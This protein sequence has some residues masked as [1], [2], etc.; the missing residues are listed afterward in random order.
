MKRI[1]VMLLVVGFAISACS[2]RTSHDHDHEYEPEQV[3]EGHAHDEEISQTLIQ[4]TD[5]WELFAEADPFVVN[6]PAEMLIHLTQL[7]DFKPLDDSFVELSISIGDESFNSKGLRI[8]PGIFKCVVEPTKAGEGL[9][10]VFIG[11]DQIQIPVRVFAN[12]HE[13]HHALADPETPATAI[14]FTK[15][16]SWKIDFATALPQ[17]KPFGQL[18]KA[19]AR[20]EALPAKTNTLTTN[21]SGVVQFVSNGLVAGCSVSAGQ[22]LFRI[23]GSGMGDDNAALVYQSAS[24]DYELTKA[25][26]ERMAQLAEKQIVSQREFQE[27]QNRFEKARAS[28]ENLQQ[29]F[30]V[31]GQLVTAEQAGSLDKVWV[32]NGDYV[33]VGDRLASISSYAKVQLV[34]G[35]QQ[36]YAAA[37]SQI[38]DI[39][40]HS[41]TDGWKDL[42]QL[43]G[44]LLSVGARA[45]ENNFLVPVYLESDNSGDF[46]PGSFVELNLTTVSNQNKLVVPVAAVLEQQS[47]FFVFVQLNPEL[48]EKRQVFPGASNGLETVIER[49]LSANERIVT[50]GAV[51]LKLASASGTLD[52]HAGHV[53]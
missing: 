27:A 48:F 43:N 37:M 36:K 13:P 46:L 47:N 44:R 6:E 8:Q 1:I 16:Q 5:K 38:S 25:E 11:K 2:N 34:A 21:A 24:A 45:A 39:A 26:Y 40:Y 19:T 18:I 9:L 30:N 52:P 41:A 29:N 23:T 33:H 14:A 15:E 4:Y 32:S 3:E 42:A 35:V 49:G 50:K 12:S 17:S 51:M 31:N 28:Y 22:Q 53:H 7:S 20:V 10:S